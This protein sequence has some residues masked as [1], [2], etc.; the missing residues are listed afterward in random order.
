MDLCAHTRLDI[1]KVSDG[2]VPLIE[3][4]NVCLDR[5]YAPPKFLKLLKHLNLSLCSAARRA[6][7]R[8]TCR[9]RAGARA[10]RGAF[11]GLVTRG[12]R[13]I[14]EAIPLPSPDIDTT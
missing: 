7:L 9:G 12:I 8:V 2:L 1:Y 4:Q 3:S 5:S 6:R 13:A 11:G 14:E 10:Q